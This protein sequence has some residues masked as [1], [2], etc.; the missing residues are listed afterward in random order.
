MR[1]ARSGPVSPTASRVRQAGLRFFVHPCRA[2]VQ[3]R[4]YL[5]ALRKVAG[6][7]A[8]GGVT[9]SVAV[10]RPGDIVARHGSRRRRAFPRPR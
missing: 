4:I 10:N 5:R 6:R 7:D 3:G 8:V 1:S 2:R 9:A